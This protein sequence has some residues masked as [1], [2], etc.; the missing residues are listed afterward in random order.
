[1]NIWDQVKSMP[2]ADYLDMH[3]GYVYHIQEYTNA[4]EK[5]LPTPC[6]LAAGYPGLLVSDGNGKLIGAIREES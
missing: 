2:N 3:T 4:K 6:E 5:G 1:M